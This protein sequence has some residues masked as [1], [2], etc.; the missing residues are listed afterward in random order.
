M[1]KYLIRFL[2]GICFI[3]LISAQESRSITITNNLSDS[4]YYLYFSS[5]G[6]QGWGNDR[7]GDDILE[8]DQTITIDLDTENSSTVINL[9]AEDEMEKTYRIDNINLL[10]A[11]TIV[12]TDE[13]FIPFGG[14][15]P[16][17][18]SLSFFNETGEDLYYLYVSSNSSM[19]WGDD[20]LGEEVLYNNESY[21]VELPIDADYPQHDLMAEG[22]SGSSY[23]I[24]NENL[25]EQDNIY[26]TEENLSESADDYDDYNDDDY[27]SYEDDY[28]E[29]YLEGYREGYREAWKEAYRLGFQDA[30]KGSLEN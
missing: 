30:R 16:L 25:I 4:I 10:E 5:K 12:I 2:L 1:K 17:V 9:M 20:I 14:R 7:L 28:H 27:D 26:F 19:Y 6:E 8:I 3:G 24:L 11:D 23:E 13:D 15:N 29:A 18:R 22:E 21:T